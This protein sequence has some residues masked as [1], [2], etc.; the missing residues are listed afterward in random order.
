MR[1]I[2]TKDLVRNYIKKATLNFIKTQEKMKDTLEIASDFHVSRTVVSRYLN[3]LFNEK[4]VIKITSRPVYYFDRK[5]IEEELGLTLESEYLSMEEFTRILTKPSEEIPVGTG[6]IGIN[7]SLRETLNAIK[8]AL[9]SH[10]D[11]T[12]CILLCG[13]KGSGKKYIAR[14][15]AESLLS[16]IKEVCLFDGRN[17]KEEDLKQIATHR[18]VLVTHGEFMSE[19]LQQG[20]L[21]YVSECSSTKLPEAVIVTTEDKER[22]TC[23]FNS[24]F[25]VVIDIPPLKSRPVSERE[26][27]IYRILREESKIIKKEIAISSIA[28]NNLNYYEFRDNYDG[29]KRVTKLAI[30]NALNNIKTKDRV[31][32]YMQH[33]PRELFKKFDEALVR[34]EEKLLSLDDLKKHI[35]NDDTIQYVEEISCEYLKLSKGE[36]DFN[37]IRPMLLSI[38]NRLNSYFVFDQEIN[39]SQIEMYEK[40]FSNIFEIIEERYSISMERNTVFIT[41]HLMYKSCYLDTHIQQWESSHSEYI[42]SI[43]S[44]MMNECKKQYEIAHEIDMMVESLLGVRF[45]FIFYMIL[46]STIKFTDINENRLGLQGLIIAHG[47]STASSIADACNQILGKN[48]YEAINMPL[49]VQTKEIVVKVKTYLRHHPIIQDILLLV[50]MGSLEEIGKELSESLDVRIGIINNIST[51]IALYIG[52]GI[53]K[54]QGMES[55]LQKTCETLTFSYKLFERENRD[56]VILFTSEAGKNATQRMMKLFANSMPYNSKLQFITYDYYSLINN[57]INDPVFKNYN[58]L[59][60]TGTLSPK[61]NEVPFVF[62]EDMISFHDIGKINDL[63][64][65]FMSEAELQQMNSNLLRNFTLDSIINKMTILNPEAL[66]NAIRVSLTKLQEMMNKQFTNKV[67]I[68]LYIHI[69]SLVERLVTK[70]EGEI[71]GDYGEF[72]AEHSDF[73]WMFNESFRNLYQEYMIEFPINEIF[74]L[75]DYII[76]EFGYKAREKIQETIY[77]RPER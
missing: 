52:E 56:N 19:S 25:N 45:E 18:M 5:V 35:E 34:D 13:E 54:K 72:I 46:I 22:L 16:N 17:V 77:S 51:R 67:I 15:I 36:V 68:G 2:D 26:E 62:L 37:Q 42:E 57:G 38:I 50:D 14:S 39:S 10:T 29:L 55:I 41:S 49:D 31:E 44:Y 6:I 43:K 69:S 12:V 23:S 59:F 9:T 27:A 33:L 7:G 63:M 32:V 71:P 40:I 64:C 75:Y 73:I 21:N 61:I 47:F 3:F 60:I 30:S 76:T 66:T 74:Y 58:V 70:S 24:I 65:R 4:E 20:V 28:I 8:V 53:I 48:V 11:E 1:E